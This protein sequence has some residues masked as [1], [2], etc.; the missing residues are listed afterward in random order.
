MC[1]AD[2]V[3]LGNAEQV[4]C[5]ESLRRRARRRNGDARNAGDLSGDDRHEHSAGQRMTAA[6]N[7]AANGG[8]GVD[9]LACG[10]AAGGTEFKGLGKLALGESA[11]VL[12]CVF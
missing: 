1:S 5:G 12:S 9:L 2:A 4:R 8:D 3:E 6:G 7:V 10:E 11:D